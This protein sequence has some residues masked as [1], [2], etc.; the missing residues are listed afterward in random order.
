MKVETNSKIV[1]NRFLDNTYDNCERFYCSESD[2]RGVKCNFVLTVKRDNQV[3]YVYAG[4]G[5]SSITESSGNTYPSSFGSYNGELFASYEVKMSAGIDYVI[6]TGLFH[7]K[8]IATS[9]A[10]IT[11]Q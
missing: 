11:I 2:K 8:M 10:N 1:R 5:K 6:D 3:G 9:N 4:A 7:S